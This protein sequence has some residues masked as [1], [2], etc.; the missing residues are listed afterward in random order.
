MKFEYWKGTPFLN[1]QLFET[2]SN[3][4]PATRQAGYYQSIP[5]FH[6]DIEEADYLSQN[7]PDKKK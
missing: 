4:I 3:S 1:L 6:F 2:Q 7:L 5:F